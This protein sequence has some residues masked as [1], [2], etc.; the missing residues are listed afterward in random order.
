MP[1]NSFGEIFR[2]TTFGESHGAGIGVVIDGAPAGFAVD[3]DVIQRQLEKRRPGQSDLA[4][5][6][7]ERDRF[8]V[9]SGIFEGR[10]TGAPVALWIR[11]GDARPEDYD[12]IRDCFR[13]GHADFTWW[14]KF[15]T[16]DFRGGGRT[17]GRE[18]AARVAAGALARQYLAGLG[19]EL[20]GHV[21]R[22]GTVT[23][24]SF[25]PL[26]V[27]RNPVR[28]ADAQA[29]AAMETA[30]REARDAGDSVGGV[31]EVIA[32]GVPAGWGDPVFDKL[33]ARLGAALLSIGAVKGVEFGDGFALAAQ[34]GSQTNDA[35]RPEGFATNHMG[36]LLGGISTG[37]PIV[38]RAA[39]KPTP[40]IHRPQETVDTAMRPRTLILEGRH[41][42]CICP[43]LVPV[44]EAMTALVLC[45]AWLRQRAA[46][47]FDIEG[48][49]PP[50]EVNP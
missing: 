21:V 36:G 14:K 10:T 32:S 18:T 23:A 40:S 30:I 3:L 25:D 12:A 41:D 35:L 39:V 31:V 50:T 17:S 2:I 42:P 15:G 47:P 44:A 45:D 8:E 48:G 1:S 46:R 13:P 27:E 7:Q 11:N 16:R 28:C 34:R 24:S 4:S 37:A 9:L 43:R 19:V 26:E 5:P 33:D 22:I 29:A 20:M 49:T 6:R 38:V